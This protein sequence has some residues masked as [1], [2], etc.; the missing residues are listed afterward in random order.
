[1]PRLEDTAF[2]RLAPP[3]RRRSGSPGAGARCPPRPERAK[4]GRSGEGLPGLQSLIRGDRDVITDEQDEL[5]ARCARCRHAEA[6][7][8]PEGIAGVTARRRPRSRVRCTQ[9]PLRGHY[10][11]SVP[12][13]RGVF[14]PRHLVVGDMGPTGPSGTFRGR[15]PALPPA[16]LA[17][18]LFGSLRAATAATPTPAD[19]PQVRALAH[20]VTPDPR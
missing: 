16:F 10:S 9:T 14:L 3:P 6:G 2:G 7:L 13:E 8:L 18:M 17:V 12:C 1:M 19:A 11:R 15:G 4:R 5:A 20:V